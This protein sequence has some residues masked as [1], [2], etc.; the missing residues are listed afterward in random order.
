MPRDQKLLDEQFAIQDKLR[1]QVESGQ[2]PDQNLVKKLYE[3]IKKTGAVEEID[4]D[5]E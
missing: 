1:E 5:D 2:Q 4:L 3:I